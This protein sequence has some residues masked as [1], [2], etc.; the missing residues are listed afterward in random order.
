MLTIRAPAK[1]NLVLE[2][3]GKYT[4]YHQISSIIQAINLYDILNFKLDEKISFSC[5]ESSLEH[6]NL[7]TAAALLLKK[8]ANYNKGAQ[9][10]LRKNIPWGTGL[11]GGSS[12]AAATLLTLNTLWGLNLS[13]TELIQLAIKLGA[14]VP[15]FVYGGTALIEGI[16]E[17]VTPLP[18]LAPTC[19]VL[20]VPP[21][22]KMQDKTKQLYAKLNA[23]H[24]TR[25][26]FVHAAQ[27]SLRKR[28]SIPPPLM[29]NVFDKVAFDSFPR[30][31]KYEESFKKAGASNIHLAGSGPCL[32]AT[33]HKR[34]ATRICL[35]LRKQ[36]LECYIV[37]PLPKRS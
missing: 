4:N 22:S 11:G 20:L 15:F 36:G 8:E 21:L 30:L 9:I 37:F 10:E 27:L 35:R 28:K 3:L 18:P 23:K 16:G 5:S 25:G 14:D 29:F 26:Q 32:F 24:F 13:N 33:A 17:K 34:E 19:F 12:D 1:I 2:V 7:V 6:D 31:N